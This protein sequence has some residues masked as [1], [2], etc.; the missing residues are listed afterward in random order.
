MKR[1]D[2]LKSALA[3]IPGL[4]FLRPAKAERYTVKWVKSS[5]GPVTGTYP[6]RGQRATHEVVV[7]KISYYACHDEVGKR[8][9]C[10]GVKV[11][12]E[13]DSNLGEFIHCPPLVL[14]FE[15]DWERRFDL[16]TL[17]AATHRVTSEWRCTGKDDWNWWIVAVDGK[18][19]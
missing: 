6:E 11:L 7:E 18:L 15:V 3:V 12:F 13:D 16:F 17:G 1:R 8:T 14:W 2:L 5:G 4:A 10:G 9:A 19:V